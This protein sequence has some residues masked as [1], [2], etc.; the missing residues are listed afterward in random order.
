[1]GLTYCSV[2]RSDEEIQLVMV[3]LGIT[4]GTPDDS[5]EDNTVM[6]TEKIL[7]ELSEVQ[8]NLA[9]EQPKTGKEPTKKKSDEQT[10]KRSSVKGKGKAKDKAGPPIKGK[11]FHTRSMGSSL[12]RSKE[13]DPDTPID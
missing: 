5:S 6:D 3:H 9:E 12:R 2:Q 11:V 8:R 7:D 4:Q 13:L 1:M 10:S